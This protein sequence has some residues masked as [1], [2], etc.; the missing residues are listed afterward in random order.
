[1][2]QPLGL[3]RLYSHEAPLHARRVRSLSTSVFRPASSPFMRSRLNSQRP[4]SSPSQR[5]YNGFSSSSAYAPSYAALLAIVSGMLGYGFAQATM[6]PDGKK[7]PTKVSYGS[8]GEILLAEKELR[9]ALSPDAVSTNK[10]ELSMYGSSDNSYHPSSPHSL[11]THVKST[12]DVVKVVKISR[13]Y[14]I[15]VT[16]YSGGT[17]L[18]GHFGGSPSGS[19]CIDLSGMDKILDIHEADSDLVC[20]A[21]AQWEE[22]NDVLEQKGIPLFFPLDPGPGATI[23]GMIGTGCS[24]TNAV[25]YGTAK[26]ELFLNLT[27]VLPSGEV[28]KTRQR[29]RKSAAGFDITKLFI[30][31]EGTLGI[32]TEATLRLVP[33]L[34]TTVAMAQFPD[35]ARACSAVEEILK[36]SSG[37]RIQCVELLDDKMVQAIN[38]C[39]GI[40]IKLPV[41]DTLLFKIQGSPES[42]QE[43]AKIVQSILKKHG[44]SQFTFA[45]DKKQAEDLWSN[46]KL[47][48]YSA[49]ASVPGSRVWTTDVCV[50][51][52]NLPTLVNETKKDLAK[53]G[54]P[55]TIVGHVGDGNFHA[56]LMFRSDEELPAIRD[57]VHRIVIRATALDGTCTG[58]HGVGVGK[59]K[60]L[61]P[62]LGIGTVELMKSIKRTID[63]ME[64]FNP[65]KLYPDD[66]PSK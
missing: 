35:V 52:S 14:R 47:A 15:P 19:I 41:R 17:S 46:R 61:I 31:A 43:A 22:I 51:V 24:G 27:V 33:K 2:L 10:E 49:Q 12:E 54:I 16:A 63:P 23:G 56:L 50:P 9:T 62:E 21:G 48:L 36:S 42:T 57:A 5:S 25:R 53:S 44:S 58:E 66:E 60:Y 55:S 20:Q 29:A 6:A 39:G 4:H 13:K 3:L 26:G 28:I 34:P 45:K 7:V 11:I 8:L 64:L 65:G 32:V 40:S 37:P 30:G 1:M 38:D 18:E 59:R